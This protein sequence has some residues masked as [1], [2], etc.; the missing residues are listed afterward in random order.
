MRKLHIEWIRIV[1]IIMVVLNHSDLFYTFYTNTDNAI[2]F[3]SS[4]LISSICKINVPL[5]MMITGALLIPKAEDWKIILKKRVVR[6]L[7]VLF[8]FSAIIY[9]LECFLWNQE[10]F[11]VIGFIDLFL[12]GDIQESYWYLYE[13]IGILL[14]LPMIGAMARNMDDNTMKYFVSLAMILKVGVAVINY[15]TGYTVQFDSFIVADSVFYVI[16]GDYLEN[17]IKKYEDVSNTKLVIAG[18]CS[19]LFTIL[20]VIWDRKMS[21]EWH[22]YILS[23]FTPLLTISV[24]MLLKKQCMK[25]NENKI[26]KIIRF[27]GSCSFGVYLVERIGQRIFLKSYIW[28]CDKTFGVLACLIYVMS[29]LALGFIIVGFLRKNKAVRRYI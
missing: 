4:L 22:E 29:I 24:Y 3:G 6:I 8:V 25:L 5:F 16:L 23:M 19:I 14:L 26:A 1:A 13:Y 27:L 11:S 20:L 28:L 15:F 12:K 10:V 18:L 17:R 2:T 7:I 9:L 21:G